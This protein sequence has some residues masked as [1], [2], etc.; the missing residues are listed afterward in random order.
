MRPRPARRDPDPR[1]ACMSIVERLAL[2]AF[3]R[4]EGYLAFEVRAYVVITDTE[5]IADLVEAFV[6]GVE[7][8]PRK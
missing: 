8:P 2:K 7:P 6:A 5:Q 4:C 3:P 1:V